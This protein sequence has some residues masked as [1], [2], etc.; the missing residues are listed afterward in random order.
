MKEEKEIKAKPL[1]DP[2]EVTICDATAQMLRKAERDGVQTA[3]HRAMEMKPCPI[4]AD[5]AC[6]KHCAMGPCRLVSKDPYG[7]VGVCG[8]TID[9]IQSR[10]FARMVASGAAAHTDHGMTMLDVFREVVEGHIKDYKI[11]DPLKLEALANELGIE[12]DG[13]P[14][15]DIAKDVYK[16]LERTYI[17]VEGEIPFMKRVPA[18]TLET[19]RKHGIVPRGAMREIMELMHRTHMGVD[20]DYENLVTQCSRT[21]L[22]DGWGGSM[23]GTEISDILFGTP[24]PVRAD[25]NMGC[26]KE[27]Q[28]N[29]I[30]HGHE[31]NLFESM[32]DSVNDPTLLKAAKEAG[33][34]GINLVG[35]CCSGAEMLCRHGIPHAGNFMSTEAVLI[36]GA[37][38]AMGVDV[39]CIKQGLAKVAEC[40][41][42]RLF[43]TN[44]R[45]RIEGVQHV[46]FEERLPRAC[47]DSIVE[48]AIVRFKNRTPTH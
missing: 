27:D 39:Q 45:C 24:T 18:K 17:Q 46:P 6:C 29:I 15:I 21:A 43:T 37:V 28:V 26:L 22:A 32:L 33:A 23:V 34:K 5:S 31:P 8:A 4:G 9:T 25:V 42:T 14:E 40:Y 30:I 36:T 44:P 2:K 41:G 10:N 12:V 3:F 38:D 20:Q 19:W 11:K 1:L 47:T 35:M 7:K 13:R 16:E 48:M